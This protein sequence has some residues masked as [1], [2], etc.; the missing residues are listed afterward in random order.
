MFPT[1]FLIFLQIMAYLNLKIDLNGTQFL[2]EVEPMLKR[3]QI[4]LVEKF[5]K[6]IK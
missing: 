1:D 5:I 2:T 6:I 3:L 4:K